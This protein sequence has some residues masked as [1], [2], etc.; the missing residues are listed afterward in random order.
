MIGTIEI[1]LDGIAQG[2]VAN[3]DPTKLDENELRFIATQVLGVD[4]STVPKTALAVRDFRKMF[5]SE[6]SV[7]IFQHEI[8]LKALLT[9]L[10]S[11]RK[12]ATTLTT[13]HEL[14]TLEIYST[15]SNY[16]LTLFSEKFDLKMSGDR[17]KIL[18]E[19]AKARAQRKSAVSNKRLQK[20]IDGDAKKVTDAVAN[21][22]KRFRLLTKTNIKL[23]EI[24]AMGNYTLRAKVSS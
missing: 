2:D 6:L 14:P 1:L 8:E 5:L 12:A 10:E 13:K 9:E 22:N 15:K 21:I 23:I 16:T 19:L 11:G 24:E 3:L 7:S 20:L 4:F 18:N 17:S